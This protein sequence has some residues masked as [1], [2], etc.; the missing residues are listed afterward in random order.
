MKVCVL[1]MHHVFA[2]RKIGGCQIGWQAMAEMFG[3]NV[4]W[5][6]KWKNELIAAGCLWYQP[7]G[8]GYRSARGKRVTR[9]MAHWFESSIR[10]WWSLKIA[11]GEV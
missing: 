3:K 10:A 1:E 6:Y 2:R 4:S 5:C 9:P 8:K 11:K 7:P